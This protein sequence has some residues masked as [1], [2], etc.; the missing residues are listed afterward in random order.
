MPYKAKSP[1]KSKLP[2]E[3]RFLTHLKKQYR[4][5]KKTYLELLKTPKTYP[6]SLFAAFAA[7]KTQQYA[8]DEL[9]YFIKKN[10]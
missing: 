7:M 4:S 1:K 6:D 8:I 3:E 5:T 2:F 10:K 9:K